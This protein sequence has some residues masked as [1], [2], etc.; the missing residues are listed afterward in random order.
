LGA[1][2]IARLNYQYFQRRITELNLWIRWYAPWDCAGSAA[3][4][5]CQ[6]CKSVVNHSTLTKSKGDFCRRERKVE[7]MMKTLMKF[8]SG[9]VTFLAMLAAPYEGLSPE[10][11]IVLAIFCWMVVWWMTQPIPWGVAALLPLVLFPAFG[12]M[13]INKTVGLYGQTIFFWLMGTVL[14]GYAIQRHGLAKRF[15][16]WFLS[17][18]VVGGNTSRLI[19]GF[20]L[21]TAICSMLISDAATV[22]MMMPVG[23]SLVAYIRT[24]GN[25]PASKQT[26]LGTAMSLACLYG[27]VTGGMATLVGTPYNVLSI[28][29]LQSLAG[30]GIGFFDW[31][32]VGVP[33]F[34][35]SLLMFYFV[36][37]M[38]LPPEIPSVPGGAEFIQAERKKLGPFSAAER[39]TSFV[40]VSMVVLFTLPTLIE[41]ALGGD[42]PLTKWSAVALSI[43][44]VP[45][46]VILLMF[47][48]PVNLKKGEFL[49]TWRE[50]TEHSP[51]NI[52]IMCTSAVAVTAALVDFGFV[53]FAEGLISGLGLG[54]YSLPIVTAAL[55][56]IGA[57]IVTASAV[58]ALFGTVL[59]PAAQ[60]IGLNPASIAILIPQMATGIMLPW[61]GPAVAIAF[62]SGEAGL[63][64]MIRIGGVATILLA[65]LV[66]IVHMLL[67]ASL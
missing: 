62:A 48:T 15:A 18:R 9:P 31:M 47:C 44:V 67:G 21:S 53:S 16:L 22:A 54:R 13:N 19:F 34:L 38:F 6:I 3:S 23:I 51:W 12:L 60:L 29:L 64:D 39:A 30:R 2:T 57:N 24:V 59:V 42:H 10:G 11:R 46:V 40:L 25:I 61:S 36:L 1:I 63:K 28:G 33:I 26:N 17:R 56:A 43:Y 52:M 49:L 65:I 58:T 7:L 45:P 20:M 35:A 5:L 55:V 37:S 14:L 50:V 32:K 4:K 8:A 66:T 41:L 27:S